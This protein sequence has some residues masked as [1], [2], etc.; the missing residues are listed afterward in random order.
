MFKSN[1]IGQYIEWD[2]FEMVRD[3]DAKEWYAKS[4]LHVWVISMVRHWNG[5]NNVNIDSTRV[6]ETSDHEQFRV[7]GS[8]EWTSKVDRELDG[9]DVSMGVM[10]MMGWDSCLAVISRSSIKCTSY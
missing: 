10:V 5:A 6:R 7:Q 2:N 1:N 8:N 4:G 3:V 9:N